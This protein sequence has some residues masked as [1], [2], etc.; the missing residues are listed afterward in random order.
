MEMV[1]D[2]LKPVI[3][4]FPEV[5]RERLA[6]GRPAQAILDAWPMMERAILREPEAMRAALEESARFAASEGAATVAPRSA[7]GFAVL[8]GDGELIYA[9]SVFRS[10][11]SDGVESLMIRR[12][13][14]LAQ[15]DGQA[16]GLI[17]GADGASIAACAGVR[18]VA[19]G[20]PMPEDCRTALGGSGRRII[21]LC[22]A[23]SRAGDLSAR[24][25]AAFGF[26]PLEARLAEALLDAANLDAAAARIGVGRETAREA[27]KKAMKKAGARRSRETGP[28][29]TRGGMDEHGSLGTSKIKF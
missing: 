6:E 22:F 26:T 4:T 2:V 25:T 17:G 15:K 7:L 5:L 3:A 18:E 1:N 9:D 12:L 14:R 19:S 8:D 20:W 24:A 13:V 16:S 23:P 21:L 11:F 28:R 27:L 10:W 29:P